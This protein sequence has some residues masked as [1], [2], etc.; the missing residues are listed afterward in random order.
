MSAV[1]IT[2]NPYHRT[3]AQN[4]HVLRL[5]NI[6]NANTSAEELERRAI[7]DDAWLPVA[8]VYA[9]QVGYVTALQ[10]VKARLLGSALVPDCSEFAAAEIDL[11][12]RESGIDLGDET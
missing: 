10:D 2:A 12:A 5:T 1:T 6:L 4:N 8:I 9:A 3:P 7:A 11:L